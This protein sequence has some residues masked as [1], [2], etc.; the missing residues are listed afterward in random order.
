MSDPSSLGAFFRPES[1]AVVGASTDPK[2]PGHIA[3]RNLLATGFKGRIYPVNPHEESILGLRCY[4]NVAEIPGPVDLCLMLL[5]A[6]FSV[7]LARDLAARKLQSGD[8]RAAVCMSA[9]FAEL[10]SGEAQDREKELVR[11]LK[12]AGIRLIG[13]N[14]LGVIDTTSGLSTNFDIDVYRRGGISVLTQSGAFGNSFL[15]SPQAT[16]VVGLAKYVSVGNM[17]DVSLAE[18]LAFLGDDEATRVVA[19]Y[20]EGLAEPREFFAVARDVVRRKPVVVLKAGR[21]SAGSTAALSHTGAVAGSDALYDGACRQAGIIRAPSVSE[22]FDMLRVFEKQPSPAGNRVCVLSHMGGPGT[23]CVDQIESLPGL[24]MAKFSERTVAALRELLSSTANIGSPE[25]YIDMTAAHTEKLHNRALRIL[26]DDANIDM[27]IQILGPSSFL[28]QQ[29]LATEVAGAYASQAGER[30]PLI[31]VVTFVGVA[32]ELRTRL[33]QAGLPVFAYPDVAAD[34]C[35]SLAQYAGFRRRAEARESPRPSG[36]AAGSSGGAGVAKLVASV[37]RAGRAT[38]LEP[39]AYALCG[40]Y[41]IRVPPFNVAGTPDAA[42]CAAGDIGYP[43]VAKV[44]TAAIVHKSDAGGVILGIGSDDALTRAFATLMERSRK[45]APDA[46]KA[47]VLV[48]KMMPGTIELVA[49]AVRDRLFGPAVMFGLGGIYIE[50]LR[51]VTFRLAPLD[52]TD[53]REMIAEILPRVTTERTRRRLNFDAEPVAR[54]LVALGSLLGDHPEIEEVD[55]NPL[56]PYADHCVAVDARVIL[57]E[58]DVAEFPVDYGA[59]R[60]TRPVSHERA[61]PC[62]VD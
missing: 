49:G 27:V 62:R 2:K 58:E 59:A 3:V 15:L 39:E 10:R 29:L 43:V 55:L 61:P 57:G 51:R 50:A 17:A 13:P 46:R 35:A 18:L 52:M 47:A 5:S 16:G 28:D 19:I 54:V 6:E 22:F 34:V 56:L 40:D 25:G 11:V 8:V 26:F 14:C 44:V 45:A 1:V 12:A 48:Q 38:L 41:G 23:I 60:L 42:V 32:Q 20:L 37:R 7:Q 24:R 33:E 31:N 21:S 30:K 36:H 9:G 53:A 4:R